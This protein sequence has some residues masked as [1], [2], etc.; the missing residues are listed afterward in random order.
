MET[1]LIADNDAL[2]ARAREVI[3][4]KGIDLAAANV[5]GVDLAP[6]R[7]AGVTPDLVVIVLDPDPEH[8][9]AMLGIL[10]LPKGTRVLAIGPALDS[11]LVLRS[12]RN[13]AHDFVD[14]EDLA[15]ELDAALDRWKVD[16][17]DAQ[18]ETGRLIALLA[19]SG[20][21]GSSTLA[22]N[23]ATVLAKEHEAAGLFDMKLHA[24]DLASLLDLKPSYTLA[25]LCQNVK[26]MD[27]VLFE[28]SLTRHDSGVHLLAPPRRLADVQHVT[29][30][31]I[32]Q[33]MDL[34]LGRFP[35]VVADLDHSFGEEQMVVLRRADVV[36]LVIR[37]DFAALRNARHT[38]EYLEQL[39]ISKEK[40]RL[41]VN[42]Y[43]QPKEIS[44]SKAEEAL[45][46]KILHYVPD[47]PKSINRANNNGVPV[48]LEA[49]SSKV[50][51]SVT[52]LA[53]SVNGHHKKAK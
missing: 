34:A 31:G 6:V 3:L 36:L 7:L 16:R 19:P 23:M 15:L 39:G 48:V 27:R 24:G 17:P 8:A 14:Q 20:G 26:R 18:A 2:A 5:I 10:I 52:T 30:E 53:H 47:D 29:A 41:V 45:G 46:L 40:V 38:L 43:G 4:H 25:D 21:S 32:K 51:R 33:A 42:R 49:P 11:K 50:S 12:L 13:G 35:Y 37:L 28:H 22:A 9:L 1:Y 44:A